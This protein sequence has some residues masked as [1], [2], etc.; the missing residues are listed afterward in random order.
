M[1]L[2][3]ALLGQDV[4][5]TFDMNEKINS[6]WKLKIE[7]LSENE[8]NIL[9]ARKE[10]LI[11]LSEIINQQ[12]TSKEL[13]NLVFVCTHNS[14]R[15]Q[16]AEL[17]LR[18]GLSYFGQAERKLLHI[19]SAG[20]EETAFNI[21]MVNALGR[22]GFIVKEIKE[23]DN[24]KYTIY[25]EGIQ[26]QPMFSKVYNSEALPSN[27]LIAI[28]VCDHA[29]ETCPYIP[30]VDK[31]IT[32]TFKDPKAYDDTPQE[33]QAYDDKVLEIGREMMFLAKHIL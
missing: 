25:Q 11:R 32:L 5:N 20:T 14:R 26:K 22:F 9:P 16:L 24:P 8:N 2:D 1:I 28:M 30:G 27:D 6:N 19:Y 12:L 18:T 4:V 3:V 21:R 33:M 15:S 31:R 23:G 29:A 7:H 10:E 17:M 13:L